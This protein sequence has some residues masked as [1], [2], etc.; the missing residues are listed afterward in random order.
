MTVSTED[1]RQLKICEVYS[2]LVQPMCEKE[3]WVDEYNRFSRLK[4]YRA[5]PEK[6]HTRK[7]IGRQK[8]VN[9]TGGFGDELLLYEFVKKRSEPLS[10]LFRQIASNRISNLLLAQPAI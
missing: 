6:G 1:R 5:M 10:I 3:N 4:E 8:I 9:L 7:A 2:P